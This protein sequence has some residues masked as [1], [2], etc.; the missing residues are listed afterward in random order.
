LPAGIVYTGIIKT[1]RGRVVSLFKRRRYESHHPTTIS[2]EIKRRRKMKQPDQTIQAIEQGL[3]TVNTIKSLAQE[4]SRL[5]ERM[6][7]FHVPGFSIALIDQDELAWTNAY[8]LMEAGGR[9]KVTSETIFQAASISKPVTAMIALNLVEAGLLDLDAD[10]NQVLRS[11]QVPENSY[12]KDHK[13]TLRSLL[14]HTAGLS[15]TGYRGYPAGSPLPSL[16]QI[17][18]GKPPAISDPVRVI[19]TPGEAF[20]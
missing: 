8:G 1:P 10:V 17:L 13:V 18:D 5:D 12:T 4:R 3:L 6:G 9:A 19:Q 2:D 11:W 16:R 7:Y 15:V 14:S 20:S